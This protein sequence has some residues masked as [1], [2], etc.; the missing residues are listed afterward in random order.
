MVAADRAAVG[1]GLCSS[2]MFSRSI[3]EKKIG[4]SA[5]SKDLLVWKLAI[6]SLELLM[7]FSKTYYRY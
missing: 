7:P 1:G 5:L 6:Q 2:S 4:L 3:A